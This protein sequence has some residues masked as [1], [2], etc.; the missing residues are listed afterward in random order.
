MRCLILVFQISILNSLDFEEHL[1]IGEALSAIRKEGVLIIGSGFCTHNLSRNDEVKPEPWALEFK[2]W[3]NDVFTNPDYSPE[4]RRKRL[5]EFSKTDKYRKA[6]PRAEH[7]LP[8]AMACGAAGYVH[9]RVLYSEFIQNTSN[10]F[11]HYLF[12]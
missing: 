9:G 10:L 7:F 12:E 5:V 1:K 11:A 3:L 4:D 8:A 2:D 6:H